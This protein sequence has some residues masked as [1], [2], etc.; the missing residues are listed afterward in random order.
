MSVVAWKCA[1]TNCKGHLVF[2]D[3]DFDF[4]NIPELDGMY[5]FDNPRCSE[6]QT[7]HWVVP[8]YTV[9]VVQSNG[10]FEESESACFTEHEKRLD[11]V[12]FEKEN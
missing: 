2:D 11:E 9:G 4:L 5:V 8:D 10:D 7:E 1:D 6:C 3:A 12:A